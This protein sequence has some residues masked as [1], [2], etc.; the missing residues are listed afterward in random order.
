M[1]KFSSLTK[2]ELTPEEFVRLC[3]NDELHELTIEIFAERLRRAD[4]VEVSQDT[5]D[6]LPHHD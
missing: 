5:N 1:P 4:H 2:I 6:T 3:T